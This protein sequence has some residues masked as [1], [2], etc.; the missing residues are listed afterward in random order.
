M[1]TQSSVQSPSSLQVNVS[2][3]NT[4]S[5]TWSQ[6]TEPAV[7]VT[8]D[9][10]RRAS[11]TAAITAVFLPLATVAVFITPLA[12]FLNG[13]AFV[14]PAVPLLLSL[15]LIFAAYFVS[16]TIYHEFAAYVTVAVPF[17][18]VAG[19]VLSGTG[20]ASEVA[21]FFLS[22]GVILSSLL[23]D[24]RG[25]LVSGV[26][27]MILV[28]LL[29]QAR[30]NP[31]TTTINWS[32][33]TFILVSTGVMSLVSR[34]RDQYIKVLE[35]TQHQL[36]QRIIEVDQ[37]RAQAERSDQVKSAF[38]ASM[39][40][41][42][43]TPLNAI[44]N[45]TKFVV[46]GELGPVNTEQQETLSEV[47]DSAKHL[48]NLINDVLDMSKIESG[49]LNLFVTDDIDL[50]SIINQVVTTGKSLLDE[51]PVEIQTQVAADL[52]S[53]RGDRQRLVQIMLNIMSN[54]CKFTETGSITISAR[55][56]SH[57]VIIAVSDTGPGIAPED[58]D[59][60]FQAFKQTTS[61]LRQGGGTGL[62]MPISKSL[63]EAH[64][65]QLDLKSSAG[66][67][68][69]FTITLPIKSDVLVP[70]LK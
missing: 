48:L 9:E 34:V 43:R 47:V 55:Q 26:V 32:I 31:E 8:G 54:A 51:K 62:G 30:P 25:T 11:T 18:A 5:R 24:A 56:A 38:L 13:E 7:S 10:R 22:L 65:G 29:Q 61:G 1:T 66:A 50:R 16:R 3:A 63:V 6:L 49:S 19:S 70:T 69:T 52:P 21:L 4:W 23:L 60:V 37:A 68:A 40:H 27:A 15:V 12:R 33:V 20:P 44:I 17:V 64:G 57:S 59:A 42:L 41:E 36:R 2:S 46:K 14:L 28:V 45:F 67:G 53:I 58:Q 35:T 39:S